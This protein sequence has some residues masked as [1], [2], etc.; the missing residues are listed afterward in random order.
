MALG[1]FTPGRCGRRAVLDALRG[2]YRGV[3]WPAGA[4]EVLNAPMAAQ[5][6]AS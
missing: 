6:A 4:A 3:A 2:G 1:P 5:W